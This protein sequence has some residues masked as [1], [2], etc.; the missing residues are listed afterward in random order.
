MPLDMSKPKLLERGHELMVRFCQA[1]E[2]TVPEVIVRPSSEWMFSPTCAFYR[3]T[4]IEICV[5]LCAAVGLAGRSW[6]YPGYAVDRT[7]YG[8][9]QHELGHHAD[10]IKSGRTSGY[11]GE[12]S[13][14]MRA[15]VG[16]EPLTSYCPNDAEWFAEMFRLFVTNPHLLSCIRPLTYARLLKDWKPVF[17]GSWVEV[18][19]G[20]PERTLQ[21]CKNRIERDSKK[22]VKR[23]T[24]PAKDLL[25]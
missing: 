4:R 10:I 14:A 5:E 2:L 23:I 11:R 15:E 21:A 1:N 8:V 16:E 18:L 7:P 17:S 25:I 22:K 3:P 12:Y 6:S 9:I 24:P 13:V 20:A 19:K